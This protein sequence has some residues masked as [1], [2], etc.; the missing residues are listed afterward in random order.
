[1]ACSEYMLIPLKSIPQEIIDKYNIL[2]LVKNGFIYIE[3]VKGM[4]GLSQAGLIE[5]QLLAKHLDK[6]VFRQTEHNP[7]LWRHTTR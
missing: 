5:N 2:P 4:Y 3:I 7:G 1:M 6:C